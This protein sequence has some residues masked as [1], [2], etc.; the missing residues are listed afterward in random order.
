M[1]KVMI[2]GA[3]GSCGSYTALGLQERGYNVVAV[4]H[5]PDDNGFFEEKGIPYFSI[6]LKDKTTFEQLP[7]DIDVV[8]HFAGAMPAKMKGYNPYEYVDSIITAGQTHQII[9]LLTYRY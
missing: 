7:K 2:I 3:T 8:L 5:R 9:Y 1:K 6:D 4:A